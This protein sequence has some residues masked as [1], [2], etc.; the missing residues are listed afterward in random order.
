MVWVTAASSEIGP[1]TGPQVKL[2]VSKQ[3]EPISP[4]CP[5]PCTAAKLRQVTPR[6]RNQE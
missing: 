1:A 4:R 5:A 2:M 3:C 6:E